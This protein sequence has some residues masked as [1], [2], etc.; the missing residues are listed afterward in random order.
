MPNH[1]PSARREQVKKRDGDRCVRCRGKGAEWHHRRSRSVRD[2]HQHCSCNG[3]WLCNTCHRWAHAHPF[4]ARRDG[5]IVSRHVSVPAS[6]P[7]TTWFGPASLDCEGGFG[8]VKE[9]E[10]G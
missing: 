9:E 7:V 5:L 6:Q 8:L 10:H 3:V 2:E 1:I 4:D